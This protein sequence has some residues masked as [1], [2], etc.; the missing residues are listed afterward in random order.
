MKSHTASQIPHKRLSC[1]F[2]LVHKL[3]PS[4]QLL[5]STA[6]LPTSRLISPPISPPSHLKGRTLV[7]PGHLS[8]TTCFAGEESAC[9][10]SSLS[11]S[12]RHL[13]PRSHFSSISDGA[14]RRSLAPHVAGASQTMSLDARDA[15]RE[16]ALSARRRG[17]SQV[18]GNAHSPDGTPCSPILVSSDGASM[19]ALVKRLG[20]RHVSDGSSR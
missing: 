16:A 9:D 11:S 3:S 1:R 14:R 5:S 6:S 2:T 17:E 8:D 10:A 13:S 7:N 20:G 12:R 4:M 18:A 15:E 19:E